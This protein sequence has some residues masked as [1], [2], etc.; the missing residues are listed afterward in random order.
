[1]RRILLG[2]A[3]ALVAASP[4]AAEITVLAR[5][6][7]DA[8]SLVWRSASEREAMYRHLSRTLMRLG[9]R[10]LPKSQRLEVKI[11]DVRPAGQFEPW[12]AGGADNVRIMRDVTPPS[13]KL[14]Y[15]LS[16]GRRVIASGEETVTDMNYLWDAAAR[17]S[18]GSFPYETELM[19]DWFRDRIVRL[20]P[21]RG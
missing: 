11:L 17:S 20:K 2:L 7:G 6:T 16:D 1:M 5:P 13:V 21:A 15:R 14:S 3:A 4:A 19:R 9:E 8:S 18:L 10:D 12:R